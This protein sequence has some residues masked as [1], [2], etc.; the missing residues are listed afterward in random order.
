MSLLW[1]CSM[2]LASVLPQERQVP[3]G[4]LI[5]KRRHCAPT[6]TLQILDVWAVPGEGAVLG[7]IQV[8]PPPTYAE[9]GSAVWL[10]HQKHTVIL[11]EAGSPRQGASRVG[12]SRGCE[13]K[14]VPGPSCH[15]LAALSMGVFSLCPHLFLP[16][17]HSLQD[18]HCSQCDIHVCSLLLTQR[19]RR[20]SP[21]L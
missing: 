10:K 13:G 14:S 16:E 12:S 6:I 19:E 7:D 1:S 3:Y 4:V 8:M 15:I 11:L 9:S 20:K 17:W 21:G 2:L 18:R 5:I